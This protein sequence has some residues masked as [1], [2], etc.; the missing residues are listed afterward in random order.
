MLFNL[1]IQFQPHAL[2][3]TEVSVK[4]FT[5]GWEL[6]GRRVYFRTHD[7]LDQVAKALHRLTS[8]RGSTGLLKLRNQVLFI[9]PLFPSPQKKKPESVLSLRKTRLFTGIPWLGKCIFL[10]GKS[11]GGGVKLESC[12][13]R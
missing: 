1:S 4:D 8:Q 5:I 9:F 3:T 11:K 10:V 12:I 6:D 7:L 2:N 13:G